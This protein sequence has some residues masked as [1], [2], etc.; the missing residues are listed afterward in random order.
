MIMILIARR[1]D[2]REMYCLKYSH[3]MFPRKATFL[4]FHSSNILILLFI[5]DIDQLQINIM[6]ITS[7]KILIFS[8]YITPDQNENKVRKYEKLK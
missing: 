1:K 7:C 5:K 8:I 6:K 3:R 2:K 4:S